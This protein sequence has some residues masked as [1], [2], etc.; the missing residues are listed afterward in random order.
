MVEL[1]HGGLFQSDA[2]ALVNA[3]NSVGVRGIG[4]AG[5]VRLGC[6][7]GGLRWADVKPRSEAAFRPLASVQV[8]LFAPGSA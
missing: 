8:L 6:G 1:G 5:E 4:S 7:N 3:V 2:E